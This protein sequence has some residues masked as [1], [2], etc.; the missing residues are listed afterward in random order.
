MKESKI[1]FQSIKMFPQLG[2]KDFVC[3]NLSSDILKL[4]YTKVTPKKKEIS[5]LVSYSIQGLPDEEISKII[6]TSVENLRIKDPQVINVIS[7]HSTITRNIEIPSQDPNEIKEIINLQAG[8]HTPYSREEI[9]IDYINL[10]THKR[11]YTKILLI[12]VTLSVIR[13]QI[14][15]LEVAGLKTENIFFGPEVISHVYSKNLRLGLESSVF[16]LV[17]IDTNF[18]DF[19]I[20]S[21]GKLIFIRSI[22][23]GSQQLINEKDRF[24][25]RFT[26][27]VKRSFEAYSNEHIDK[28]PDKFILTGA[29]EDNPD[30][31]D[32]LVERLG[33]P[34]GFSPY[35]NNI[36]ISDSAIRDAAK[37][38]R[39]SFLDVISPLVTTAK[40]EAN[41]IP[42][43]IKLR[44]LFEE[45]SKD[46]VK[47]GI[48]TL[49]TLALIGGILISKIYFRSA[50]LNNL[51]KK[52]NPINLEAKSLEK[53][54]SRI[55]AVKYYLKNRG[56]S[57]EILT[58]L[59]NLI[60]AEVRIRDI[61]LGADNRFTL[62]GN[63]KVM[64]TVFTFI[65][66]M[67]ESIYFNNVETRRTTKRKEQDEE[68]VDFEIVCLI[69]QDFITKAK[70]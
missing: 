37:N 27:E 4:A 10:G 56:L 22:P 50:Y 47:I 59:Y 32:M 15:I 1:N 70:K 66:N 34:I 48:L 21:N 29:A 2:N 18:T 7:A 53:N 57:L 5:S 35:F 17:H 38:K 41:F 63:A 14:G 64:S 67:E 45:K 62:A 16:T 51:E 61:R 31:K 11:H 46:L 55:E 6:K 3:L 28:T 26:E 36:S 40:I 52:Y 39:V 20:T 54:F 24:E 12:I 42:E 19:I 58:E 30:I 44:K 49:I 60:P 25:I 13:R 68:L 8:R 43:E 9:I 69:N 65:A 33:V 23:I